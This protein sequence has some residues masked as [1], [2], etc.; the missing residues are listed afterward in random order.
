MSY[1]QQY[2]ANPPSNNYPSS[3]GPLD[4]TIPIIPHV[5][6]SQGMSTGFEANPSSYNQDNS[7][8]FISGEPEIVRDLSF[9]DEKKID[10]KEEKIIEAPRAAPPKPTASKPTP[11]HL[12]DSVKFWTWFS[13]YR[14]I[15]VLTIG[16]QMVA[17]L[18]TLSGAW[19]Y[20]R[21]HIS[22]MVGGNLLVAVGIRSEWV[23]RFLYWSSIK[24]IRGWA[25]MKLRVL[26]VAFLYHIDTYDWQMT[27]GGLHSGCG[28]GAML[29]LGLSWSYHLLNR[30]LYHSVVLGT[31]FLSLVIVVTTCIVA[32]PLVRSMYHNAFEITHRFL[33][34]AGVLSSLAFVLT[35]SWW[36]INTHS[37]KTS[38]SY[39]IHLEE[40][41]Y[42]IA[43]FPLVIGQ[44]ITVRHVPVTVSAPSSKASVIRVPGGL[45]SGVHTRVSRGGLREWHIFGSVSEGRNSDCHYIVM[46]V[47]GGFTRAM[48]RDQPAKLYTKTWKVWQFVPGQ[49]LVP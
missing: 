35:S 14:Q 38:T 48:N 23:M 6:K 45:T 10:I 22:A 37:W 46:A 3:Q 47:Q 9:R 44:W 17:I 8:P 43:L 24:L 40:F 42:V 18:V 33:G 31:L 1:N 29:W 2:Y 4:T 11:V 13:P 26:V 41:W 34:W 36:D 49:E 32:T 30:E 12:S 20:P 21:T 19:I 39:L 5:H 27:P 7:N 16:I 15:L 28:V 25:P